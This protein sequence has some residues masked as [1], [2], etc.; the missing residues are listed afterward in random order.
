MLYSLITTT[1]YSDLTIPMND[2]TLDPSSPNQTISIQIS[3]D[4]DFEG[5]ES[6]TLEINLTGDS[7]HRLNLIQPNTIITIFDDDGGFWMIIINFIKLLFLCRNY[8]WL[9]SHCL[10]CE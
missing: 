5:V 6:F 3:N 7:I 2:V 1:S 8:H 4:D 10:H 9:L